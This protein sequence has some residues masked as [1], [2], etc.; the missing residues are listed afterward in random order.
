VE[1]G[2]YRIDLIVPDHIASGQNTDIIFRVADSKGT[3]ILDLEP[4]MA[5]EGYRIIITSDAKEFLH[6]LSW[7]GGPDIT[8]SV[9]FPRQGRIHKIWGQFQHK[10]KVITAN[11]AF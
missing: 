4:L 11:Y 2:S 10:G 8:F 6:V 9:T 7:R 5:A 3:P 1:N